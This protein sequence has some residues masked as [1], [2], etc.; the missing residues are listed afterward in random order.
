MILRAALQLREEVSLL[1]LY[2]CPTNLMVQM[3]QSTF[4]CSARSRGC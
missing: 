3:W 2:K 4:T 1:Q